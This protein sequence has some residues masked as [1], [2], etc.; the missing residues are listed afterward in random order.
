MYNSR[1]SVCAVCEAV[2]ARREK[3]MHHSASNIRV[4]LV[5]TTR[6]NSA[7]RP[8]SIPTTNTTL[9]GSPNTAAVLICD[10]HLACATLANVNSSHDWTSKFPERSARD[11]RVRMRGEEYSAVM[12]YASCPTA[13]HKGYVL[14]LLSV[15]CNNTCSKRAVFSIGDTPQSPRRIPLRRD[16]GL[17]RWS[18]GSRSVMVF[19]IQ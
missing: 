16:G 4:R 18:A 13:I 9:A 17:A 2:V 14:Q 15:K 19:H 10:T 7:Q 11:S 6:T 1:K 5:L 12:N 8:P 3:E